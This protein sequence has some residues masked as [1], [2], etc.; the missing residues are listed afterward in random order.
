MLSGMDGLIPDKD[1]IGK[2]R[3]IIHYVSVLNKR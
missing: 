2:L 1:P 3:R